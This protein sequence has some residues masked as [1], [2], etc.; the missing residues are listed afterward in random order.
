M[1]KPFAPRENYEKSKKR[2]GYTPR[3]ET[4]PQTYAKLGFKC[5]LEVHQQLK[6]EKKLFC[7]C[8]A[9]KYHE[10]QDYDAEIVRH[11]RPTLSELGEYD[12]T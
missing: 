2:V 7:N 4:K 5:G 8:P 10:H 6:T 1:K 12:G 9:G 11:M 3:R